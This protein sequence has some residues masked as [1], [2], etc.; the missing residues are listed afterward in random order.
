MNNLR[1][2]EPEYV[3]VTIPAEYICVYHRLL[4]MMADYGEDMLKDCKASCTERNSNVIECFNLFNAAVAARKL[5]QG[6][7]DS[8]YSKLAATL[9]KYIK[10]KIK[11][12]YQNKDNS[13]SFTFP[14]DEN[15]QL[16]AFVSCGEN[17]IFKISEDNG[18]LYEHKFGNGY[19]NH[20]HLN[21]SEESQDAQTEDHSSQNV[22]D[23]ERQ[24]YAGNLNTGLCIKFVPMF[25][26]GEDNKMHP[27]G[28]LL[29]WYDG[30][31]VNASDAVIS[32]Y[33][34]GEEVRTL[35]SV[36]L[37]T[38]PSD[39]KVYNFMAVV[40]YNNETKIVNVNKEYEAS[41]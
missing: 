31:P 14:I 40:T 32:Y 2:I 29:I 5:G 26:L 9:I 38:E 25:E 41:N 11:Q 19:D 24:Y 18:H 33:F 1:V 22:Y 23:A 10:A 34:E 37:G 12:I 7:D 17:P 16:K 30:Q 3:Y 6:D 8:R 21:P 13:T 39:Y 4:A 20:L 35:N 15:G 27:C 28:D 36:V